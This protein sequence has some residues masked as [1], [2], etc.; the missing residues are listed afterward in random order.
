MLANELAIPR[1]DA[2]EVLRP[3]PVDGAVEDH[4]ADLLRP[5]LLRD[6]WKAQQGIDLAVGEQLQGLIRV[7]DR[8][9]PSR[10]A[11]RDTV[12]A[13]ETCEGPET[14]N[15]II[16][17]RTLAGRTVTRVAERAMEA[18][19]DSSHSIARQAW[20]AVPRLVPSFCETMSPIFSLTQ[21]DHSA[22]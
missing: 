16:I 21:V 1:D 12:E 9:G 17:G 20:S 5:Q 11:Y 6:R 4:M 22:R 19:G 7:R 15:R 3:G 2:A 8:T 14:T 10:F 13:A 18:V